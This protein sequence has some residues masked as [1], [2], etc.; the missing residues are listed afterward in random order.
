MIILSMDHHFIG[1]RHMCQ[2]ASFVLADSNIVVTLRSHVFQSRLRKGTSYSDHSLL[3]P[4]TLPPALCPQAQE[5][6]DGSFLKE[7]TQK[8]TEILKGQGLLL[9]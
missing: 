5:L 1:M 2:W 9:L 4:V 7:I 3:L 6:L 8:R